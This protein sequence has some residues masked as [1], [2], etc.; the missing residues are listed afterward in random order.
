M[1]DIALLM[2]GVLTT[3][4]PS[5]PIAPELPPVQQDNDKEK[6]TQGQLSQIVSTAQITPPEFMQPEETAQPAASVITI[7]NKSI[8]NPIEI[9]ILSEI[10][11]LVG[12]ENFQF[13]GNDNIEDIM[14]KALNF[15]VCAPEMLFSFEA[16]PNLV[17]KWGNTI[18]N[19]QSN[20]LKE[21]QK[22]TLASTYFVRFQIAS[23]NMPTAPSYRRQQKPSRQQSRREQ[24]VSQTYANQL[25][26]LSFGNSGV[27]VRV[28]QKLLVSNGYA[29]RVDGVFGALTETAVQAFQN[30][31]N[32]QVDG[33]VGQRTWYELTK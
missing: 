15:S 6:L 3:G 16:I 26:I 30:Q 14:A 11:C 20:P 29:M 33:I 4:Q 21:S 28:L 19:F 13:V 25:P 12:S 5:L 22:N 23:E 7:E 1:T 32:I 17:T 9:N 2:T 27:T 31:R 8:L 18:Q 24:M 10:P